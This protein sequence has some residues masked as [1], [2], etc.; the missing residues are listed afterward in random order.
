[1]FQ[2]DQR[3]LCVEGN[4]CAMLQLRQL[5]SSIGLSDRMIERA[6]D[7]MIADQGPERKDE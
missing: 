6:Y 5:A 3:K 1:M 4:T 2:G 7:G